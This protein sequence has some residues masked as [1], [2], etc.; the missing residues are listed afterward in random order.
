MIALATGASGITVLAMLPLVFVAAVR[1][2]AMRWLGAWALLVAAL[3][4]F[5]MQY[6]RY[7]FP[8][9]AVLAVL[10]VVALSR[11]LA[12]RGFVAAMLVLGVCL[13][14]RRRFKNARQAKQI[15]LEEAKQKAGEANTPPA[16]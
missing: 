8:A 12:W 1:K 13:W 3:L 7:L 5:Q 14:I 10:G 9:Y 15:A 6:L 4:F 2:P 16:E 11:V